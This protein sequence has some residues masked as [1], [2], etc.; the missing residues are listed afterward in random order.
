MKRI[1]ARTSVN[2]ALPILFTE[3]AATYFESVQVNGT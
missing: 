1:N 2:P 3:Q